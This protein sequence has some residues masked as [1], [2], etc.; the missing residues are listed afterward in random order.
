MTQNALEKI[1]KF[2][3]LVGSSGRTKLNVYS[4]IFRKQ[5][6]LISQYTGDKIKPTNVTHSLLG[7]PSCSV[8]KLNVTALSSLD[9]VYNYDKILT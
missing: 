2:T 8:D 7:V 5:G 1:F 9:R 4:G 6:Y 3:A